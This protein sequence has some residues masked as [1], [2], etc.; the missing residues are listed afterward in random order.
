MRTKIPNCYISDCKYWLLFRSCNFIIIT[1]E[2]YTVINTKCQYYNVINYL[3]SYW[4]CCLA[5]DIRSGQR[6]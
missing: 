2:T 6:A 5:E 1:K 4:P 3:D